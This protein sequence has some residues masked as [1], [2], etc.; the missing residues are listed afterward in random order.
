MEY[1]R[2]IYR[3]EI[4]FTLQLFVSSSWLCYLIIV[5]ITVLMKSCI[6]SEMK[7][8]DFISTIIIKH[9]QHVKQEML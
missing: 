8:L 9:P 5:F 4:Q 2:I 3:K 1:G 7:K 6:H